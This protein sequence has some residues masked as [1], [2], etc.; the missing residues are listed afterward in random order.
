MRGRVFTD[1]HRAA[2]S[3]AAMGHPPL[4]KY[5]RGNHVHYQ[6]SGKTHTLASS[7]ELAVAKLLDATG[8]PWEY[9]GK[10]KEHSLLLDGGRRYYPDF[11]LPRL[12]LFIDPKGFD[13]DPLKRIAVHRRY[14]GRVIF[15]VGKTYL[16]QLQLLLWSN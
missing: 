7:Y 13:R 2:L 6:H 5:W 4:G 11:F 1:S 8:E 15:L 3:K 14:P 16:T 10:S 9:V 12:N